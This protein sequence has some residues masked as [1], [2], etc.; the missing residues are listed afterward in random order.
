MIGS[1]FESEMKEIL[2]EVNKRAKQRY[3]HS[4][5][6]LPETSRIKTRLLFLY[7]FSE[8]YSL[9]KIRTLCT[10][11][12]LVQMGLDIHDWVTNDQER[13]AKQ[14]RTRQLQVLAGDYFSSQY[15]ELLAKDGEIWAIQRLAQSVRAINQQ[16]VLL[17]QIRERI[18]D[19]PERWIEIRSNIEAAVIKGLLREN[20]S[21]WGRLFD[22]FMR[23]DVLFSALEM[24]KWSKTYLMGLIDSTIK[25]IL[26]MIAAMPF[27][28]V[29][30]ELQ[31]I[32][33]EYKYVPSTSLIA[34]EI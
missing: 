6:E 1:V 19:Y 29:R 9:K 4:Q 25:Q 8:S 5:I 18:S 20:G 26:K 16:K 14:I 24:K 23:I 28:V 7:L 22:Q 2:A 13:M 10:A 12:M 11:A 21:V 3:L 15:Y 32:I 31:R 34:E 30:E 27:G 33:T 17:Y